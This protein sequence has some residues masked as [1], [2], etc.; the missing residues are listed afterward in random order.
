MQ[1][2]AG[3]VI[4]QLTI[5]SLTVI[6]PPGVPAPGDVTLTVAATAIGE[7]TVDGL[8]RCVP[9]AVDVFALFTTCATIYEVLFAL[10]P[11]PEYTAVM[12]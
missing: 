6:V 3:S 11:S 2:V 10:V 8:G 5:P 4:T 9:I 1:L 12:L 7:P